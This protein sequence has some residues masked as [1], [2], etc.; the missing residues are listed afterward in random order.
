VRIDEAYNELH[1]R[2]TEATARKDMDAIADVSSR[3]DELL[4]SVP[5]ELGLLFSCGTA[6]MQL[7]HNGLAIA[8]Y[9]KALRIKDLP[10]I[11][12]NLGTAYKSEN[13]NDKARECWERALALREDADYY[14]NM[15]TL[16]INEG[17]PTEGLVWAERGLELASEHPRP[18]YIWD[19]VV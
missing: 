10:E 17:K 9:E 15:A 13:M 11:W 2:H 18:A 1:A 5:D 7:G 16:Y 8:L 6:H 12:N 4:N 14:N 3:Y 19:G